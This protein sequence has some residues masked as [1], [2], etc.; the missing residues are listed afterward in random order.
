MAQ[1]EV[2]RD[3]DY[4]LVSTLYHALQ[5]A[6]TSEVYTKDAEKAGDSEL[7]QYFQEAQNSYK[8]L[9]DRAKSLLSKRMQ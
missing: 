7:N 9:A 5:G 3:K 4:N 6:E 1:H 2:L 8:E